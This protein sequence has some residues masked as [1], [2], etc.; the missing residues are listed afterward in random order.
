MEKT[1]EKRNLMKRIMLM[2]CAAVV[3]IST[4]L[5]NGITEVKAASKTKTVFNVYSYNQA[6][7]KKVKLDLTGN[8]KKDVVKFVAHMYGSEQIDK[9]SIE[10]NGKQQTFKFKDFV[11]GVTAKYVKISSKR[12]FLMLETIGNSDLNEVSAI[13]KYDQ[14]SKK[15]K[16]VL[17]LESEYESWATPQSGAC[18]IYTDKITSVK[19]KLK[20]NY[21]GQI[22]AVGL[23]K[24]TK[25]YRYNGSKFVAEKSSVSVKGEKSYIACKSIPVSTSVKSSNTK[26]YIPNGG[27]VKIK[28][29]CKY[30][31][32]YYLLVSYNGKKG[33][34]KGDTSDC[35]KG[36]QL[37]G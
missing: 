28:K 18:H 24:W 29:I 9:F 10:V 35:F 16:K 14:K 1:N 22:V 20:V 25:T 34:M 2:L 8:G 23:V 6:T 13:Y 26:F 32:Q 3:A 33:W 30:K 5:G 27:K 17:S 21:S 12:V 31:N 11:Y 19:N 7:S 4:V 37:F 15:L 36:V